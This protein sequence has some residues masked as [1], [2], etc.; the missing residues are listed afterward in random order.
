MKTIFYT[1]T[2]FKGFEAPEKPEFQASEN[3]D[4]IA[5]RRYEL[6]YAEAKRNA[7]TIANPEIINKVTFYPANTII[8]NGIPKKQD[9]EWPGEWEVKTEQYCTEPGCSIP[10]MCL[11]LQQDNPTL[12]G[13]ESKKIIVLSPLNQFVKPENSGHSYSE[14]CDIDFNSPG[15]KLTPE[16][17]AKIKE[18]MDMWRG[19]IESKT[20]TAE[21]VLST[22]FFNDQPGRGDEEVAM[23]RKWIM[24][25]MQEYSAQQLATF[26]EKLKEYLNKYPGSWS[27]EQVINLIDQL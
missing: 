1:G 24:V 21:E 26:K 19:K 7:I 2:E 4:A 17:A 23:N 10:N 9:L 15:T 13:H 18:G 6:A 25:A 8:I 11:H 12:C 3:E 20:K 22:H 14:G 5:M 16:Q 27:A